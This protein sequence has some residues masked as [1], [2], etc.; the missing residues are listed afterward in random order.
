MSNNMYLS[1]NA[2]FMGFSEWRFEKSC[3]YR[4]F[5]IDY[6]TILNKEVRKVNKRCVA[7]TDSEYQECIELLRSGFVLEDVNVRPNSKVATIEV[8]QATLGLRLGDVLRLRMSSFIRDGSRW[9]LDFEEQKTG[10][11]RTF[12]V[13]DKVYSFI[14]QYAYQN[15]ISPECKLFDISERQ[16]ERHLNKVFLKMGKDIRK[17]GSHSFRKYFSCR[18]YV[19]SGY[20]IALVQTLLQ[21]ASANTTKLY[22]TISEKRIEEAL[23]RTESHII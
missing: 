19:D 2:Y 1:T 12:T 16:V 4:L 6:T 17:Y 3:I 14:Q 10:K 22:L 18:V 23:A 11:A 20:D 21:H 8:I 9:R 5:S 15:D 7:L 13:P